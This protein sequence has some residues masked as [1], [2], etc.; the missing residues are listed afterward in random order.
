MLSTAAPSELF[1]GQSGGG[2]CGKTGALLKQSG[3]LRLTK[4][5]EYGDLGPV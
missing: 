2:K 3:V 1:S 4:F 5:S